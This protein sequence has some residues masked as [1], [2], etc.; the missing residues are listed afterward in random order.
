MIHP[1]TKWL[2]FVDSPLPED[3]SLLLSWSIEALMCYP[4]TNLPLVCFLVLSRHDLY[5]PSMVIL[6]VF[7]SHQHPPKPVFRMVTP[8]M[9]SSQFFLFLHSSA[10]FV[11]VNVLE[12]FT[13]EEP[14]PVP[15]P[16]T[17]EQWYGDAENGQLVQTLFR[18]PSHIF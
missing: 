1:I 6:S 3:V 10:H 7:L 9:V 13:L 15:R 17:N 4:W 14:V 16:F 8:V 12:I 18:T 11:P 5:T 2:Y